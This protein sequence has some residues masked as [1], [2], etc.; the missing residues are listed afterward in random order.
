MIEGNVIAPFVQKRTG[1]LPPALTI[2][3][4]TILGTLFGAL[5]LILATPFMAAL[6]VAVRMIY[7]ESV[8]E[9][10][11]L[12]RDCETTSSR[13]HDNCAT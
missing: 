11:E 6:L 8:M 2:V 3:S 7:V 13:E 4:Q 5:G 1:T 12:S 9:T 10:H